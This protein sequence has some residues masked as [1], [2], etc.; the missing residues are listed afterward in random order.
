MMLGLWIK[1]SE[2]RMAEC[3]IVDKDEC[4][5]WETL[6]YTQVMHMF[7]DRRTKARFDV[8]AC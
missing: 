5:E 8:N 1:I 2:L 4:I 7:A 6:R 3:T